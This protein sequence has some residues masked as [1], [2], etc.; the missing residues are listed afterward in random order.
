MLTVDAVGI[1]MKAFRTTF[2]I[3]WDL[4]RTELFG[5]SRL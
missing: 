2:T 4:N 5:C 3:S 1:G